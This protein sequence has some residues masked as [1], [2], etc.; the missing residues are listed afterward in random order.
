MAPS[1][2]RPAARS[3]YT[4]LS[5]YRQRPKLLESVLP[6]IVLAFGCVGV[7]FTVAPGRSTENSEVVGRGQSFS[8]WQTWKYRHE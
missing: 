5:H 6:F 3:M 8:I 7:T 2:T 4:N 1:H